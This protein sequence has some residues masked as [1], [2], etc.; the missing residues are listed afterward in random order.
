MRKLVLF[1]AVLFSACTVFAQKKDWAAHYATYI[2]SMDL[3]RHLEVLASDAYE[4]RETGKKGQQMAATYLIENFKKVGVA[5]APGM[6]GFEQFFQVVETK[7]GG[8]ISWAGK[9][10]TFKTDFIYYGAKSKWSATDLPMMTLETAKLLKPMAYILVAPVN[11]FELRAEVQRLKVAAPSG[12]KGIVLMHPNY[13][14]V[15]QYLEHYTTTNSMRLLEGEKKEEI[16]TIMV[17]SSTVAPLLTKS[18]R[19][20]T[21]KGKQ[22]RKPSKKTIGMFSGSLN[23]GET[24]LTSSNVLAFIPGSDPILSKEIVV[25]TAH[26]DHIGMENGVVF[27]GADDDGT[28]TVALLEMAEAFMQA[29]REGNGVRRSILI[30]PV[31]GEEKGLLGSAYYTDHPVIPLEQ[32]VANLNIDMIGRNDIAHENKSDYIYVI[33]ADR[34]SDDLHAANEWANKTYT[35]LEL[36]Y[37]FNDPKDP[38]QFYYRS[39]HYNFAKNNIPS[40]FYFSGVHEDYHQATDDVEKIIFSKVEKVTRLVFHTAWKLAN[41]TQ[42][43]RLK[44]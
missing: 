21:G 5:Q 28:G 30:M 40:V 3:R 14:Q 26:Y 29:Y 11:S 15:Y 33:G 10:L 12:L 25:I 18:F 19:Y 27:N 9:A 43:P 39:D 20:L 41:D 42:R 17:N 2:D 37:R 6:S 31:S 24:V 8:S 13:E 7:P 36:D 16:P 35:K 44:M 32:T 23:D 4:G 34:L 22:P 38:N 1:G